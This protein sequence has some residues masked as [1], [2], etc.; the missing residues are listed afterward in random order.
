VIDQTPSSPRSIGRIFHGVAAMSP[1][2]H[3]D[4]GRPSPQSTQV[5]LSGRE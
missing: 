2:C 3:S 4:G 5:T 1:G